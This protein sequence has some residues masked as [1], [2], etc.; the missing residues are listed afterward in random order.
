MRW[1]C[2]GRTSAILSKGGVRGTWDESSEFVILTDEL[3][4]VMD[5]LER[6]AEDNDANDPDDQHNSDSG[7]VLDS[8][9]ITHSVSFLG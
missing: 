7:C 8:T 4:E 9:C 2:G 5:S 6:A 1:Q 3:L